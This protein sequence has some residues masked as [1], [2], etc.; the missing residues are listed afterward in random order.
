MYT[1]VVFGFNISKKLMRVI[2][3]FILTHRL[4]TAADVARLKYKKDIA[5]MIDSFQ[6]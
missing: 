1:S 5:L 2:L 6:V 4:Q 3:L